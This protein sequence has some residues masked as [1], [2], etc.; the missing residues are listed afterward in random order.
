MSTVSQWKRRLRRLGY[1]DTP[2]AERRFPS[3]FAARRGNNPA[4]TPAA[5]RNISTTGLCLTTLERWP[6][7][8]LAALTIQLEGAP[9][10]GSEAEFPIQ[11]LV[12]RH[13]EDGIGLTFVLPPGLSPVLWE[14]L[15]EKAATL[16]N[17]LGV[18]FMFKMLRTVLFLCRICGAEADQ[19]IQLL[20]GELDESRTE[21]ALH[22]AIGAEQILASEAGGAS[23]HAHPEHVA[24]LIKFGSWAIGSLTK[25]LW[26]GL[27]ATSCTPEGTDDSNRQFVDLLVNVTPTQALIFVVACNKAM[28]VMSEAEDRPSSRILFTPEEMKL[29]TGKTDL[30]RVATDIAYLFHS[31]LVDRNF[32]FTSYIPT[33]N[34]DITPAR[35]GIDFYRNCQGHLA[36][37]QSVMG[38]VEGA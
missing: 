11:A 24:H 30:T 17:Q 31:G 29:L 4:S 7:S 27:L 32:D 5:I 2:R 22:I 13:G 6:I 38:K 20:G 33:E 25:Q 15:I 21:T 37:S 10:G 3:G 23:L 34:F 12:V 9:T 26:A 16:T 1:P 8:E 28:A 19:A 36:D 35:L 14:I 18:Q